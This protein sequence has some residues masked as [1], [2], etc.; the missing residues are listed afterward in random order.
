[1]IK[2]PKKYAAMRLK[3]TLDFSLKNDNLNKDFDVLAYIVSECYLTWEYKKYLPD[4]SSKVFYDVVFPWSQN[5]EKIILPEY[6]NG[7]NCMNSFVVDKIFDDI[8]LAKKYT[9]DKNDDLM[10]LTQKNKGKVNG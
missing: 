2:L 5:S 10:L 6:D 4:G 9:R 3:N 8:E 1:M 7:N